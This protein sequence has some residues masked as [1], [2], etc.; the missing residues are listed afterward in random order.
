MN[1]KNW[2]LTSLLALLLAGTT[3][4]CGEREAPLAE[5]PI[6]MARAQLGKELLYVEQVTGT[7]HA[8]EVVTQNLGASVRRIDIP[9]NPTAVVRRPGSEE[10]LVLCSGAQDSNGEWLEA[11]AVI[12]IDTKHRVR[13][14]ELSVPLAKLQLSSDGRYA[15]AHGS[16]A[17]SASSDLLGNP[18]RVALIDLDGAPTTDNPTERTLK[19]PGGALT[20]VTITEPLHVS[21]DV[22]PF[23]VFTFGDGISVWDLAHPERPEIS[24]EGLGVGGSVSLRRLVT[25]AQN[26]TLYIIQSSMSDL[27][28][29]DLD[30]PTTGKENDYWPTWNQLPL[31]STNATD[32][33]LFEDSGEPRVLAAV[34]GELRLID[35]NDSRVA[36]IPLANPVSQFFAFTGTAPG[37]AKLERRLLGFSTNAETVTFIELS[38]LESRGTRNL[39]T[40]QLGAKLSGIVPL[41]DT[42]LLTKFIGGG[43]GILD[44]ESRRFTPLSS[45]VELNS[46]L[47]ESD[48]RRVWV[49]AAHDERIGYFDPANLATG[50]IRLDAAVQETFLFEQGDDRRIVV[51]HDN[52]W[53]E[54]TVI[55]ATKPSRLA[56]K[57]WA[58]FL[59]DGVVE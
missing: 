45:A 48:A 12:A 41:S 6:V 59:L 17:A 40:L 27:R 53:G 20:S 15:I 44:L 3:A 49:G 50:Y 51:T 2:R 23:G 5:A 37:D 21:G 22:R 28:V 36:A 8:L 10:V 29:L 7:V 4:G 16:A 25:D 39:E 47:I 56:S 13:V 46:P 52:S 55:N 11:P 14:Y 43:I 42:Q 32:L 33:F 19:A 24:S 54:V 35:A 34:G 30:N 58:G 31:G 57:V 9:A 26:A 18:N 1:N 38:D